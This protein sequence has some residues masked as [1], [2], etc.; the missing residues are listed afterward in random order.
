MRRS[1]SLPDPSDPDTLLTQV[2]AALP[3]GVAILDPALRFRYVNAELARSTGVA[4]ADHLGQTLDTVLPGAAPAIRPL[5]QRVLD[6]GEPLTGQ[7]VAGESAVPGHRRQ[8]HADYRPLRDDDGAVAGLLAVMRDVTEQREASR[9]AQENERQLRGIL[10]NLPAY[11]GLLT[12]DGTVLEVNRPPLEAAGLR[13]EDVCGRKFWETGWWRDDPQARRQIEAATQRAAQGELQ[14]F[15]TELSLA[16]DARTAIDFTLAP[17]F[18]DQG[19]V[20]HLIPSGIDI[21]ARRAGEA[22]LRLSEQRFR[23]VVENAPDG[24]AMVDEQGQILLVNAGIERMF[25]YRRDQLIG[26]NVMVL[27]PERYRAAHPALMAGF[28]R[29]PS[30]RDMAGR[31]EL[32]ALRSDGSE[33]PVEIGLNPVSSEGG[34]RVLATIVDV[35]RRKADQA[36]LERALAEKTAL[37]QEVHHRVKNNLQVI[38]SLLSLQSRS[39]SDEARRAL[40]ESQSRVKAMALIHQLLYERHDFSQVDIG[41]YLKRLCRLLQDTQHKH[42]APVTLHLAVQHDV[43]LDLQRAVPCGLLI[44][45]LV[46]NAYKHAFPAGRAGRIEVQLALGPDGARLVVGDDGIGLP[47]DIEQGGGSLGFQLIPLLVDQLGGQLAIERGDGTRFVVTFQPDGD[48]S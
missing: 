17:L 14:R 6:S 46:T 31:R 8:W 13:R 7:L 18:D 4:P 36:E 30:A 11:V 1:I 34:M 9:A 32:F 25:L 28:M 48:A 39:A 22:A 40:A 47:D 2:L 37:L 42:G 19:A 20:T 38:S 16:G 5:L 24:L 44:N 29:E 45:E 3:V 35:T 43:A 27:M 21:T 10:D 15:D 41:L 12:P 26:R 33:F 23:Q